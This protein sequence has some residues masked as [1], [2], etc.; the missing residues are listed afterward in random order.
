MLESSR[1]SYWVDLELGLFCQNK[2][3]YFL[4]GGRCFISQIINMIYGMTLKMGKHP[5]QM[6]A[7]YL[8]SAVPA[9]PKLCICWFMCCAVGCGGK[10]KP[11]RICVSGQ[12]LQGRAPKL[13]TR[14]KSQS[15]RKAIGLTAHVI[16][17]A[18]PRRSRALTRVA[19]VESGGGLVG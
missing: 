7:C 3:Y 12:S 11:G 14:P 10:L 8:L 9:G 1:N 16:E 6:T 13:H 2:S 18:K 15:A 17:T 19:V 5:G 4:G